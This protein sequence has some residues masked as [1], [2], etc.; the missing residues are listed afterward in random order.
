MN[1][2]FK[3]LRNEPE[4]YFA[5][6]GTSIEPRAGLVKYGPIGIKEKDVREIEIGTIATN[7]DFRFTKDFFQR[8]SDNIAQGFISK[9][10]LLIDF[11]GLGAFSPLKF[12][13]N[14]KDSNYV[15][16]T[17][18]E[19]N[20]IAEKNERIRRAEMT[21]ELVKSKMEM[22]LAIND[23]KIEIIV[24]IIPQKLIDITKMP[25]FEKQHILTMHRNVS[26]IDQIKIPDFFNFHHAIK[27]FSMKKG[28]P[29]QVILPY[30]I[31]L[32]DTQ[33]FATLAWN[34]SVALYYKATNTPWKL[35][36]IQSNTC[37]AGI[38]FY[39]EIKPNYRGMRTAM[40]Q[41]FLRSGE[42]QVIR[43][44]PFEWQDQS[45]SPDL[46]QCQAKEIIQDIIDLFKQ[47]TKRQPQRLVLYKTSPFVDNEIT[48]FNQVCEK[49]PD[50]GDYIHVKENTDFRMYPNS[51]FPTLRGT[52]ISNNE[53][54]KELMLYTTGFVP[55]LNTYMGSGV[56]TPI[57]LTAYRQDTPTE[58]L[59]DET[60]AL[61][62]LDW[63][64]TNFCNKLPVTIGVSQKV[65][66]ILSEINQ[67][68]GTPQQN[69]RFY[70]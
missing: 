3:G 12:K 17:K 11:P 62:K 36:E 69:Y 58:I 40:A 27:V 59:I 44:K 31:R 51:Q 19:I 43:G 6:N 33:D 22:L 53:K 57:Q 5:N 25:Q 63:N 52:F 28:I 54:M 65:G 68:D 10:S 16:I 14:L 32:K 41:V 13:F 55:A 48:G 38:S 26:N 47:I 64:N 9:D 67:I 46:N 8:L 2:W 30:T 15:S 18:F 23:P 60:L 39:R 24:L 34:L 35:A 56:P 42:S 1:K 50:G 7:D 29:S 21:L 45:K 70:M 37:Y 4:L 20:K 61:T 66:E 49:L